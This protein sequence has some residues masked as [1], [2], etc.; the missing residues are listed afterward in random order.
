MLSHTRSPADY[1]G[2]IVLLSNIETGIACIAASLPSVRRLYTKRRADKTTAAAA[3][4]SSKSTGY[5]GRTIRTIG[6]GL[7]SSG[8]HHADAFVIP[9]GNEGRSAA[10]VEAQGAGVWE[11]AHYSDSDERV[12]LS[13]DRRAALPRD[14]IRVDCT[15]AVEMELM[16]KDK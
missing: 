5:K 15:Y 16:N 6:G 13:S 8:G 7:V 4:N 12:L 11:Q 10:A 1:V 3:D 2:Y 9:T 14:M